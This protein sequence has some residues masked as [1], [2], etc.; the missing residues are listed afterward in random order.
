MSD[1]VWDYAKASFD[2][3]YEDAMIAHRWF[4]RHFGEIM[5][6]RNFAVK[7]PMAD[8]ILKERAEKAEA[9][10]EALGDQLES[11]RTKVAECTTRAKKEIDSRHWLTEGRG[12]YEW[13]DGRYREE[14]YA[15]AVAIR[16]ALQPLE[17]VSADWDGCPKTAEGVAKARIDLMAEVA[18]LRTAL[19]SIA[20]S[21]KTNEMVRVGEDAGDIR[22]IKASTIAAAALHALE[23]ARVRTDNR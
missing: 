13:D 16:A 2:L 23:T 18:R 15:A 11:D 20:Q 5:N 4:S 22:W 21:N 17:R 12:S 19:E 10:L 8:E 14:F 1:K 7:C 6:G 3:A 9:D